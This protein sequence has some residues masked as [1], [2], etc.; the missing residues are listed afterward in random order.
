ML[1]NTKL[2]R[3]LQVFLGIL[4]ATILYWSLNKQFDHDELEVIHTSWKILQG[5]KIYVDFFQ[6]HHPLLYYLLIPVIARFGENTTTLLITRVIVFC[7]FLAILAVTYLIS[8]KVF[9]KEVG[10]ISLVL[11]STTFVFTTNAIELRPDVPQTLFNLF[12]ILFLLL[13]L[14]TKLLKYI[15]ISGFSA[16]LAFLFLQKALFLI[17][18]VFALLLQ[19][20]RRNT[21]LIAC[22]IYGFAICLVFGPYLLYLFVDN[23]LAA[24][25]TFNWT[26][27][28]KFLDRDYPLNT[29]IL[30]YRANAVL[31]LYYF[32]SLFSS[33]RILQSTLQVISFGLLVSIF[34]L[35]KPH[36]QY[37]MP[38]IPLVAILSAHTIH[39]SFEGSS[40]RLLLVLFLAV[41]LPC[42]SL[43]APVG[44]LNNTEQLEKI[45]FVLSITRPNDYVYDGNAL[46]NV[47]RKDID[48]FWY[49]VDKNDGLATY[50]SMSDYQYNIYES[51]STL[52]PKVISNYFIDNI[53]D[54]RI[55]NSYTQSSRYSDLF[56]RQPEK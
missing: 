9:S 52:K 1:G 46:F 30:T 14:E 23:S 33:K 3:L 32:L 17:I 25:F 35:Q 24:Y 51:I 2:V 8:I 7:F 34:I 20:P 31:W 45:D 54:P 37:F 6:H 28:A 42:Y 50:K 36:Q 49:S 10:I 44:S 5:E 16:G 22:S 55:V 19:L 21:S 38:V 12:S 43:F 13:Y 27:N 4:L 40:R 18:L 56:I 48:F 47:F 39:T 26:L 41:V 15:V 11:L 53:N 29:L